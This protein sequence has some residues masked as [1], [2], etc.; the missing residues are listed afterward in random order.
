MHKVKVLIADKDAHVR[1]QICALLK[2]CTQIKLVGDVS[3][4]ES[5]ADYAKGKKADVVVIDIDWPVMDEDEVVH[6]ILKNK[7]DT[8]VVMITENAYEDRIL[9]SLQAGADSIIL[10]KSINTELITAIL[11]VYD[12]GCFLYP[13]VATTLVKD[14]LKQVERIESDDY[15]NELT[16]REKDVLRRIAEGFDNREIA[17]LICLDINKVRECRANI[18]GKLA[19][20]NRSELV[21]YAIR[22]NF[23]D[24][25]AKRTH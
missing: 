14:Y 3:E 20:S 18:R 25:S 5:I 4:P 7:P 23:F 11:T 1:E 22:H 2:S 16:K 13:S 21:K 12:G 17:D 6:M 10:K 24:N 15:Y 19:I 9:R 8:R